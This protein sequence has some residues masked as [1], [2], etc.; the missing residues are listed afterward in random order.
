MSAP[1]DMTRPFAAGPPTYLADNAPAGSGR[2]QLAP[3]LSAVDGVQGWATIPPTP[4]PG[5]AW[6]VW[7]QTV[8]VSQYAREYTWHVYVLLPGDANEAAA[9][10]TAWIESV[11][12]ALWS[13]SSVDLAQPI[14]LILGLASE[15]V[16]C[17]RF[18]VRTN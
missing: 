3:V 13:V 2:L 1:V 17:L 5:D 7:V 6:S 18:T 14:G 9:S 10:A 12:A 11:G 16:P 4:T 15:T 8:W